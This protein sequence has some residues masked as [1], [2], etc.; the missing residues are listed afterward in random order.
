MLSRV[1]QSCGDPTRAQVDLSAFDVVVVED[2][3]PKPKPD[4]AGIE[5]ALAAIGGGEAVYVGDTPM[6]A[7]VASDSASELAALAAAMNAG[8]IDTLVCVETNPLYDAP[9]G[10]GFAAAGIA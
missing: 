3:V 5:K 7:E 4:P 8:S 9:A 6:D 2:D 1:A 10:S